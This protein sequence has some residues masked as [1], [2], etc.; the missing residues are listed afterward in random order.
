MIPLLL[1]ICSTSSETG[2]YLQK[3]YKEFND[4]LGPDDFAT[5]N[6]QLL[7]SEFYVRSGKVKKAQPGLLAALNTYK[8]NSDHRSRKLSAL[9][10]LV[11]SYELMGESDKATPYCQAIGEI[12]PWND[13]QEVRPIYRRRVKYPATAAQ[14]GYRG[15]VVTEFSVDKNGFVQSPVVVDSEGPKSF[16]RE[17]LR[18]I[19][20]YR[21]APRFINGEP[22]TTPKVTSRIIFKMDRK[23]R[24]P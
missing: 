8:D 3:A 24:S 6:A 18:A 21:Y 12:Q 7:L 20:G 22:V 11:E 1:T 13:D 17:A 15:Y 19:S 4:L 5:A 14:N 2:K 23:P 9:S 16:E 10:L